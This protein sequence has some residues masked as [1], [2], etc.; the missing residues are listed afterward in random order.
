MLSCDGQQ[1]SR[2]TGPAL[3]VGANAQVILHRVAFLSGG[4]IWA[5][6]R[7]ALL[8]WA[9]QTNLGQDPTLVAAVAER[10]ARAVAA[11]VADQ[12]QVE[13]RRILVRPQW[14]LVTGVGDRNNPHEV[15]IA[16]HGTYGWPVIPG[17]TMK[18]A[19]RAWATL[20]GNNI[21]E[22]LVSKV[23]GTPPGA[24]D[25]HSGR[26][27]IMDAL[28]AG[29]PV[30]VRLDVV[31]PHHKP[32]YT[33][34]KGTPPTPPAEWH[35]PEPSGFLTIAGGSFAVDLIGP[36]DDVS[37]VA[38]WCAGACDDL[39]IGAKTGAGYGYLNI[40]PVK[41]TQTEEG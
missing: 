25:P 5:D 28:P 32:Y 22:Q 31:T 27:I 40:E 14:R 2:V 23:L 7:S 13:H 6:G 20:P 29:E 4:T 35:N 24:G 8:N 18:G 37:L 41:Y 36:A 30:T 9:A 15:G 34:R 10:R 19:I 1:V 12:G 11:L 17:S 33:D 26:V 39:G 21:D 38:D 3:N 16:L